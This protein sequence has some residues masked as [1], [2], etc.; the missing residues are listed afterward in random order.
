[1]VNLANDLLPPIIVKAIK[2][3]KYIRV[4]SNKW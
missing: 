2:K 1:M 4:V 3:L